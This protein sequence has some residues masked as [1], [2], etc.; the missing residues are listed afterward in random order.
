[1]SSP[2]RA[3]DQGSMDHAAMAASYQDEAKAAEAKA[4]SH[5]QEL[6]RLKK[7]A[8]LPKG[9]GTT[10]ADMEKHCQQLVKA[11]KQA[12]AQANDLAKLHQKAAKAAK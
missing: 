10:K 5:Q 12:E 1:M 6:D 2:L 7:S 9:S 11:Y 8:S 3:Q 4:A